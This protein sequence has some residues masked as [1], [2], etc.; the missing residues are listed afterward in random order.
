[1]RERLL[2]FAFAFGV[3]IAITGVAFVVGY[4]VGK[5]IL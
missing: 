5:L 1:M 4:I 3:L 2:V